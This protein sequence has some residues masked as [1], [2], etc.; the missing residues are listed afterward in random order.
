LTAAIVYD[1]TEFIQVS[2]K[3]VF[4]TLLQAIGLVILVIF[5]FLQDWRTT[6]IPA[7]AIPVA[8]IGAL[9]FAFVF[10][11]SLNSFTLFG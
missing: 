4:I 5:I 9:G 7:I 1:T 2:I 11:F 8:L 6:V 10:G 3:E